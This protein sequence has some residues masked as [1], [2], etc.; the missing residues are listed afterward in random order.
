MQIALIAFDDFTD[1]DLI[2]HWDI[3]NRVKTYG[4][5]S[6]WNVRILGTKKTHNSSLGLPIPTSGP[7][8]AAAEAHAVILCSGRG[9]RSLLRD[10]EY[11]SRLK[12][13]PNRQVLG[14]QCSGSLIMGALGF[15]KGVKVT[16]YPP[17]LRELKEF[18]AV[19]VEKPLVIEGRFAT[20]SS[21]LAGQML[22]RWMIQTLVGDSIAE[23]VMETVEPLGSRG[24]LKDD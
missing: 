5:V 4:G 16:A 19:P 14:A 6:D 11:L 22:S 13:D 24:D 17:I 8:D 9:T 23:R 20:A 2:L 18:E 3:L 10:Q 21:C 15:L 1:L 12:I 7:I